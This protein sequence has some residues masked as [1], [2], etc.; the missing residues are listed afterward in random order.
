MIR[1]LDIAGLVVI[2]RAVVDLGPGLT[3]ITGETGAGKSVLMQSLALLA[4]APADASIVRPGH[5][6]ALVQAVI[7]VPEGFWDALPD[8][9]PARAAR[10]LVDSEDEVVVARRVPAEGRS[11]SSIDGQIVSRETAAALVRHLVRFSGQGDQHLLVSARSQMAVL[12]AFAGPGAIADQRRLRALRTELAS[13]DR[14]RDEM[15]L[16]RE[17]T[18]DRARELRTL[19]E[20]LDQL[21][22]SVDERAQLVAERDRL[23]HADSLIAA[24]GGA[25]ELLS[26][27][28]DMARGA[29]ALLGDARGDVE[30]KAG[31]DAHLNAALEYLMAAEASAQEAAFALRAYVDGLEADPQRLAAVEDRIEEYVRVERRHNL[32]VEDMEAQGAQARADLAALDEATSEAALNERRAVVVAQAREVSDRLHATRTRAAGPLGNAVGEELAALAMAEAALRVEVTRDDS[33]VPVDACV[34]WFRA[35]PGMAE[36]PLADAA[37][38][39]ELSRVLLAL[40][41]AASGGDATWVFDEID[42]GVGGTTAH[43]VAGRLARLADDTQVIVITHLAQ[44]AAVADAHVRLKKQVESDLTT[45]AVDVL[46][47]QGSDDELVRMLGGDVA[48]VRDLVR[49][50]RARAS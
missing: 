30:A 7:A 21:G 5:T 20:D 10:E 35:N 8:G 18:A 43:A 14:Q 6:A 11:R 26:P 48:G 3:A 36:A 12:D 33:E 2:E 47:A 40:H 16:L 44:V 22:G 19:I 37:S 25:A 15:A 31:V 41:G 34:F 9:D 49:Q 24:A 28:D 13:I 32:E 1:R 17:R 45:T 23:R 46:D 27:H 42:A 39:G 50:M 4:G 38:G 29:I